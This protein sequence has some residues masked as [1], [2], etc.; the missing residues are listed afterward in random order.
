MKLRLPAVFTVL[1]AATGC[2]PDDPPVDGHLLYPGIGIEN[3][4]FAAANQFGGEPWV[5]FQL[6][7]RRPTGD[8]AGQIDLHRVHYSDGREHL[9]IAGVSERVDWS[10]HEVDAAG[11]SYY[12]IDERLPPT[13]RSSIGTLARVDPENGVVETLPDVLGYSLHGSRRRFQ[14]RSY[15]QGTSPD[16]HIRTIEG[17]DRNLGPLTGTSQFVGENKLYWIGQDRTF[18]RL[19]GWDSEPQPLRGHV[20]SFELQY[21]E[22]HAVVV[23]A[24][25]NKPSRRAILNLETL[26]ERSFPVENLCCW[27]GLRGNV[28]VFGEAA[29]ESEPARLH[30]YD[31][32]TG[33]HD[34]IALPGL[35]DIQ[36]IVPRPATSES[37]F[38]DSNGQWAVLRPGPPA[39]LELIPLQPQAMRFASDGKHLIYIDAEPPPPPPA[40][41]ISP[42]GRLM[43]QNAD[44]WF[45]P[46]RVLSPPGTSC[47]IDPMGY[48]LPPERPRQVI[49]WA[50]YGLGA[51]DLYLTDLDT[52]QTLKLAVGIGAVAIGGRN[53]L[54]VVRI[55]QDLTGD[56]VHRDFLTGDEQ[57]IEHSVAAAT[58]RDDAQLGPIVAFVVRERM[59]SSKR[60]GLW[61][62]TLKLL[63]PPEEK[64]ET[65]RLPSAFLE[66]GDLSETAG[67]GLE[68]AR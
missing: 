47:L 65:L 40:M 43:A 62:S 38:R 55:N 41:N 19:V 11:L 1:L 42:S 48:L 28:A 9:V 22:R 32:V 17:E 61:G 51:S 2:L 37:L 58:T 53:V 6:R 23:L 35:A 46:P 27:Q 64:M 44:D 15:V 5:F 68:A 57:I 59:A 39:S 4:A 16:L 60:N 56:L 13:G 12:M 50:R 54:G 14:Y 24:E 7:K 33:K 52:R 26:E 18:M 45:E 66:L 67:S 49:F 20:S 31:I 30:S 10:A 34:W 29:T 25:P 21:Q 36:S 63:P 8:L 3:P